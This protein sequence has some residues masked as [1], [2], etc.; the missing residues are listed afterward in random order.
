MQPRKAMPARLPKANI[1]A[2]LSEVMC[3]G[4][5]CRT[6]AS[7]YK[8]LGACIPARRDRRVCAMR[9]VK[10]HNVSHVS[11]LG[12]AYRTRLYSASAC[13]VDWCFSRPGPGAQEPR[14]RLKSAAGMPCHRALYRSSG[15]PSWRVRNQAVAGVL[16]WC[17]GLLVL[18]DRRRQT[19]PSP[20]LLC[21]DCETRAIALPLHS[22]V[23]SPKQV[24]FTWRWRWHARR[25]SQLPPVPH[26]S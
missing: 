17:A 11:Q 14:Y 13:N 6:I 1:P 23:I 2:D 21:V 18:R 5:S 19:A 12:D 24:W 16:C 9:L 22:N 25:V 15:T 26:N 10:N 20:L 4:R 7:A 8:A 3:N